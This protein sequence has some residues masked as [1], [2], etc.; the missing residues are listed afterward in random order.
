MKGVFYES[1]TPVLIR[2]ELR[3][4]YGFKDSLQKTLEEEA[5]KKQLQA[6]TTRT[7]FEQPTAVVAPYESQ[8]IRAKKEVL[9]KV[10]E[11][12]MENSSGPLNY[13]GFQSKNV[14]R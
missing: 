6:N 1:N 11:I 10:T 12:P 5:Y 7:S 13:R 4:N 9:G 14:L 8:K 3:Y 2:D